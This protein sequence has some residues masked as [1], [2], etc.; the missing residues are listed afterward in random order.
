MLPGMTLVLVGRSP[1]LEDEA[2][3][4]RGI[5]DPAVLRRLFRP[6]G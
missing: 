1:I 4:T 5:E 6:R 2:E 3:N